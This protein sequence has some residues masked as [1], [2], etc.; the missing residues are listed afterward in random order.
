MMKPACI[1]LLLSQ[2]FASYAYADAEKCC[3]FYAATGRTIGKSTSFS[4]D[5]GSSRFALEL[6]SPL[7]SWETSVLYLAGGAASDRG[8]VREAIGSLRADTRVHMHSGYLKPILCYKSM[9]VFSLCSGLSV[10][11]TNYAQSG[12]GAYST[13]LGAEIGPRVEVSDLNF[14]ELKMFASSGINSASVPSLGKISQFGV[15]LGLGMRTSK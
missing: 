10:G 13:D 7:K 8:L 3:T 2:L 14:L 12:T 15:L 9:E 1:L 5:P 11:Y 4:S 6:H